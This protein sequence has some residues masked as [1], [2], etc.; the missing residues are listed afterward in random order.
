[1]IERDIIR[2]LDV[3]GDALP[4]MQLPREINEGLESKCEETGERPYPE[5]DGIS[6][7]MEDNPE[8]LSA[9]DGDT[10]LS[11]GTAPPP[12]DPQLDS[13]AGDGQEI[14][15]D[16]VV[17]EMEQL[18][19]ADTSDVGSDAQ[20]A[21]T[22]DTTVLEV[23]GDDQPLEAPS[24]EQKLEDD[25]SIE[26]INNAPLTRRDF[27]KFEEIEYTVIPRTVESDDPVVENSVS[28][29][30]L[31]E[32]EQKEDETP[33]AVPAVDSL[34]NSAPSDS[35]QEKEADDL[36]Q[37]VVI[38]KPDPKDRKLLKRHRFS[39][40]EFNFDP[41]LRQEAT[42]GTE[43][44]SELSTQEDSSEMTNLTPT[45]QEKRKEPKLREPKKRS[46][47]KLETAQ[48]RPWRG[49]SVCSESMRKAQRVYGSRISS[50]KPLQIKPR[51]K[52]TQGEYYHSHDDYAAY[53][54]SCYL[55][56]FIALIAEDISSTSPV[57]WGLTNGLT[58]ICTQGL[59]IKGWEQ[60]DARFEAVD[61]AS[62]VG[63][64]AISATVTCYGQ[65]SHTWVKV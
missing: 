42:K 64:G 14:A 45:N 56:P 12:D 60:M 25:P 30:E 13:E 55:S 24:E 10:V 34:S 18:N 21:N 50:L 35:I 6:A 1:M 32:N 5:E 2:T 7:G 59:F 49:C 61:W 28:N 47:P 31:V 39:E 62:G 19:L 4:E 9:Q 27:A 11:E 65:P 37:E 43:N 52:P 29:E 53:C 41:F 15:T 51:S 58:L 20:M 16:G 17:H 22:A 33:E 54:P 63:V 8:A 40:G 38:N 23:S 44:K 48:R 36:L 26:T 3:T 46:G 57:H